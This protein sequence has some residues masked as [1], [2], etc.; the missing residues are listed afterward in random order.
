MIYRMSHLP[1]GAENQRRCWIIYR[2]ILT[3][4]SSKY[5][6][7]E[8]SRSQFN[9]RIL[10]YL[11]VMLL[12]SNLVGIFVETSKEKEGLFSHERTFHCKAKTSM[13]TSL[14]SDCGS[15]A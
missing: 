13:K 2:T 6:K 11:G 3:L 8:Y 1:S 5:S 14:K 7:Y 4:P 9:G 15:T 10:C 12:T